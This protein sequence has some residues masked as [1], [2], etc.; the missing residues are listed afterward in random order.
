MHF[1]SKEMN[2][3]VISL[4]NIGDAVLTTALLEALKKKYPQARIDV[5]LS[6]RSKPVFLSRPDIRELIVFDKKSSFKEKILLFKGLRRSR[7]SF[8]VDL[9]NT[10]GA[11][12][13]KGKVYKST[14]LCGHRVLQHLSALR[15]FF[16]PRELFCFKPSIFWNIQDSEYISSFCFGDYIVISPCARSYTKSW[17]LEYFKELIVLLRKRYQEIK[18]VLVGEEGASSSCERLTVDEG[19]INFCAKTTISELAFLISKAKLVICNDSAVVHVASAVGKKTLAIFGPTSELKYGPLAPGSFVLRRHYPC[20]PCEKAQCRFKDKRCLKSISIDQVYNFSLRMLSDDAIDAASRYKR[21][22]FTRVDKIG[23]LILTTPA[24]E[25][26]RGKY[27]NSFIA[28]LADNK[29]APL[30]NGN[31]YLDEV[32]SLNKRGGL[33]GIFLGL[34]VLFLLRKKKFDLVIN[35]HPTKRVHML[36]FLASIPKR[37]GYDWK[38][39]F[40]N[41]IKAK[42]LKQIGEKSEADYNFDLLRILGIE[43]ISHKQLLV[44][45]GEALNKMEKRLNADKL[46][47]FIVIHPGA[48]CKSK[49]WPLENFI[50]FAERIKR[51]TNFKV[52]FILGPKE[53]Y[54]REVI[55]QRLGEKVSLYESLDLKSLVALIHKCRGMISNDSG[56]MHIGDAFSKPLLVL[57]GRKQPGLFFKR[58]GPLSERARVI[59]KDA[60]CQE[61]LAHNCK[62]DFLCLKLITV[63][64]VYN[65]FIDIMSA[66]LK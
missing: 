19:V 26:I 61:C 55:L 62:N 38:G 5:L 28:F 42:H 9:R 65:E 39:G 30:L 6:E 12:Y 22:L 32:I 25:V 40:L 2:I 35:F 27:P 37:V 29:S 43:D 8:V 59:Y 4:S 7:Y 34:K 58:W 14:K 31:P 23:D 47:K 63:D 18:I 17:A 15:S 16:P 11:Y 50:L 33:A 52:V 36:S 24:I 48:S 1:Q 41:N 20:S 51:L 44:P 10:M 54:M 45:D 53:K 3:L 64:D 46:D 13:I 49:I 21:I 57:F 60:H 56:P 66:D